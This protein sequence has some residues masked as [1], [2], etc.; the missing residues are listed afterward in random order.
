M[1]CVFQFEGHPKHSRER[2]VSIKVIV[3]CNKSVCML[4]HN[5]NFMDISKLCPEL[6]K[7]R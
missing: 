4:F 6:Q 7:K 2:V 5:G 3:L 1:Y